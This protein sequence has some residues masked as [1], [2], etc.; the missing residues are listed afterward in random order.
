MNPKRYLRKYLH[1]KSYRSEIKSPPPPPYNSGVIR[2][3][4]ETK[5]SLA[6][7]DTVPYQ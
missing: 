6:R 5:E 7:T 3:F 2:T 4:D 1:K